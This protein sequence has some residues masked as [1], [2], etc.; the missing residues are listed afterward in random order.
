MVFSTSSLRRA[1]L[2]A[3]IVLGA[4]GLSGASP[5]HQ[6][7]PAEAGK[8]HQSLLLIDT[9]ND[10]TSY[11]VDGLDIGK[12]SPRTHTDLGR[13]REGNVGAVFFAAYVD[14]GYVQRNASAVR[15]LEMIDTIRTDIVGRYPKDF[16]L[17]L[18]SDDI[19]AAH[20]QGKIAALIGIE[21]GHAI[22]DSLRLLRTFYALGVRYM[23]LTHSNTNHWA[24]S[25]GD[26]HKE[27]VPHH[28]G[29][30]DFG[31]EVVRE[32]N[33]L[34]MMVDVSHVSDQ[35]FWDV[36]EVS[37]APVMASHSSCRA[38]S[39]IPRNMSDEMIVAMAR[40]GGVIQINFGSDFLSQRSANRSAEIRREGKQDTE[41]TIPAS[42]ADVVAHIDHVVR[43]AGL[44]AV[45][46][47][48]DFDGVSSV[49]T[50]LEDVSK[51]PNLTHA[52]L[53][54]GYRV[55]DLRKIYGGNLLRVMRAS[56]RYSRQVR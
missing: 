50:G 45:G 7:S 39:N 3:C 13:L 21:G 23:T 38:L 30:T 36:L 44:E 47:G 1:A 33:R 5:A 28:G 2:A 46:I 17:A 10:V 25:S 11:T 41:K 49:P 20:A 29:L 51:F 37:G 4:M 53:E 32:M 31:R 12:H 40:K 9:H 42:I 22:E 54:R 18:T 56:E 48:S 43:L 6:I 52:L 8:V 35:T 55:E 16:K 34:G 26:L 27:G 15:A 19:L 14:A 24:D